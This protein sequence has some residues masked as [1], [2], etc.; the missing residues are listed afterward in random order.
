[1]YLVTYQCDTPLNKNV[2]DASPGDYSYTA[3][4]FHSVLGSPDGH[5]VDDTCPHDALATPGHIDPNPDGKI[6]HKGCGA[7]KPDKTFWDPILTSVVGK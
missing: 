4:V 6:V 2:S 3:A 5:P 1:M 7:K